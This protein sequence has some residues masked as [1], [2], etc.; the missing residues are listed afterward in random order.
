MVKA[1]GCDVDG[2]KAALLTE[3]SIVSIDNLMRVGVVNGSGPSPVR[4]GG[5]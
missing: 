2:L 1:M 4:K 3:W 5:F